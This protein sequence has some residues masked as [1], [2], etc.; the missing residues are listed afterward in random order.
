MW[1][2]IGGCVATGGSKCS[3]NASRRLSR[4]SSSVR[5]WLA[6]ST[7]RHWETNQ[8]PSR[9]TVAENGRFI[10][11]SWHNRS[12]TAQKELSLIDRLFRQFRNQRDDLTVCVASHEE[13]V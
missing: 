5:P 11:Q 9:Q 2:T 1:R 3:S 12:S 7:S 4:A 6:T 13:Y 10:N 8:S